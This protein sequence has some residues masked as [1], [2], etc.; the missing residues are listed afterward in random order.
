MRRIARSKRRARITPSGGLSPETAKARRT[1]SLLLRLFNLVRLAALVQARLIDLG[2][3]GLHEVVRHRIGSRRVCVARF[4]Q[5]D[6]E[7]R[8]EAMVCH[9]P[10]PLCPT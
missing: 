4:R 2:D 8:D 1:S 10:P 3:E 5:D 9:V 6:L 7:C